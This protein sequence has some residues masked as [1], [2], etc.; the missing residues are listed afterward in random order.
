MVKVVRL[1]LRQL[2]TRIGADLD[3]LTPSLLKPFHLL[4][5]EAEPVRRAPRLLV[6]FV[7]LEV[8]LGELVASLEHDEPTVFGP[9]G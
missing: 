3:F 2:G 5:R 6:L 7:A 9:V 4:W 8:A 1:M